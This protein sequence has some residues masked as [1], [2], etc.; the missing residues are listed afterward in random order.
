MSPD[1]MTPLVADHVPRTML[2][3]DSL[4]EER[5]AIPVLVTASIVSIVAVVS[6]LCALVTLEAPGFV[7]SHHYFHCCACKPGYCCASCL[8]NS[9][10]RAALSRR[11]TCW[12]SAALAMMILILLFEAPKLAISLIFSGGLIGIAYWVYVRR[13]LTELPAIDQPMRWLSLRLSRDGVPSVR[14]RVLEVWDQA[15]QWVIAR[16]IGG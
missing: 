15:R 1:I 3:Q 16:I 5:R 11:I 2:E 8:D 9:F 13:L 4:P 7:L 12:F 6:W 10:V 14:E